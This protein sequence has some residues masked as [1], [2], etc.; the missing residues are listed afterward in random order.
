VSESFILYNKETKSIQVTKKIFIDDLE[1][2][3]NSRYKTKFD[4]LKDVNSPD[5]ENTLKKYLQENFII[6][7]D[8]AELS[9]DFLG[10]EI[11]NDALWC[12]LEVKS[13]KKLKQVDVKSS[14]I[15]NVYTN[16]VNLI[17]LNYLGRKKSLMLTYKKNKEAL[18]FNCSEKE[19]FI[20]FPVPAIMF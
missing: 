1:E 15:M 8:G 3:I 17:Y 16:Q 13:V 2:S 7:V 4:I 10:K 19:I 12:Y 6:S 20:F 9:C 11:E 18:V 14:L 5:F